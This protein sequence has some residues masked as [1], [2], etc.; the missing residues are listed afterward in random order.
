MKFYKFLGLISVSLGLILPAC[1]VTPTVSSESVDSSTSP[2]CA[3]NE[4]LDTLRCNL[5][6]AQLAK[7]LS[8]VEQLTTDYIEALGDQAGIPERP[9][10]FIPV[11]LQNSEIITAPQAQ[12]AFNPYIEIIQRKGWWLSRAR[13]AEAPTEVKDPEFYRPRFLASV[14]TGFLAARNAGAENPDQLLEIAQRTADYLLWSQEQAGRGLF[15]FPNLNAK[16][17]QHSS[18]ERFLT[19]AE[20]MGQ[21]NT[22]LVND[23]IVDDLGSGDLTLD[24]A[25]AGV[26]ILE[27]YQATGEQKYLEA[28]RASADWAMSQPVVP[29]WN[30][31]SLN[32]FLLA[33]TYRITSESRYLDSAKEK[34]RLG[35]YPGQL[36]TGP[37]KGFWADPHNAR[38]NYHY[39]LVQGLGELLAALPQTDPE[40]PKVRDVLSLALKAGNAT[41]AQN[42]IA[43]PETV[44]EVLSRL[45]MDLPVSSGRLGDE[46]RT[47]VLNLAGHYAS[48]EFLA[49]E[50]LPAPGAWGLFLQTITNA[51]RDS[52]N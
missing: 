12:S 40:L 36:Q 17:I 48:T 10:D 27:M 52:P 19:R 15:P 25:L 13:A 34:A 39:I 45:E 51:H 7:D 29:N 47:E 38:L 30:Y 3:G 26:A 20:Q 2:Y 49:E 11:N 50:W 24:N 18:S 28:A 22:V 37:H 32:V 5:A 1:V 23:W 14:V 8:Q 44:L 33:R 42:G 35:I 43:Y 9:N 16:G 46:D 31:N 21:L 6:K 4:T 41:I